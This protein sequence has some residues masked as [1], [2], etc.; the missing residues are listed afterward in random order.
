MRRRPALALLG[1]AA[2]WVPLILRW[3]QSWLSA[4]DQAFGWFV[5]V[6]AIYLGIERWRRGRAPAEPTAGERTGGA[7]AFALGCL[8]VFTNLPVLEANALWPTAQWWGAA[9]ATLAT[10][11]AFT[12]AGGWLW[13]RQFLFPPLFIFTALTWP[14]PIKTWIVGTLEGANAEIA[15]GVVS[16]FGHPAV[17]SGNVIAVSTGMVGIEEACSGLRS[18]QTVWMM[19]WFAGEFFLLNLPRRFFLVFAAVLVALVANLGRT[20]FL[21]WVAADQGLLA[22]ERWH[23]RA[24]NLELAVDLILVAA[25]AWRAH[26]PGGRRRTVSAF[27]PLPV[28][29][30][31]QFDG[32]WKRWQALAVAALAVGLVA[33][34]GT[35]AWYHSHSR[36]DVARVHWRLTRPNPN[37]TAVPVPPREIE[38]LQSTQAD[39]LRVRPPGSEF[40]AWVFVVS[41]EGSAARSENPEWHDPTICLPAAGGRLIGTLGTAPLQIG[42][43]A[44]SFAGYRF[45]VGGQAET[46]YFCHWDAENATVRQE[47]A[48]GSAGDVRSRRWQR[49]R[50]GRRQG[51]VAH[52]AFVIETAD[53]AAALAWLQHWAPLLLQPVSG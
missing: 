41:W 34:A 20:I 32:V 23:D 15:A 39:G 21:T 49:V 4:P 17:V 36:G 43:Q 40:P 7:V 28:R 51:D 22:S 19:A 30:P 14:T 53:A 50:E 6:F 1:A 26:R 48:S 27:G 35:R 10:L 33:E 9:G 38:V 44:L 42:P 16:S 5:P 29:A 18:L 8:L 2:L 12:A 24:G 13:A 47:E 25:L 31:G 37:W 52:I 3:S 46:V 45:Q 11:G